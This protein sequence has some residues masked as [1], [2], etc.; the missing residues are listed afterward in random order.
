MPNQTAAMLLSLLPPHT[1]AQ[2]QLHAVK[3]KYSILQGH[4]S[5]PV[6]H[7]LSPLPSGRPQFIHSI[8][9]APQPFQIRIAPPLISPRLAATQSLE[10][11]L[12]DSAALLAR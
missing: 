3:P 1:Q 5:R 6:D 12:A 10:T 11:L 2:P 9:P 4:T 7:L 8:N